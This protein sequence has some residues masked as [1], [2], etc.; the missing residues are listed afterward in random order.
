MSLS[1]VFLFVLSLS[2]CFALLIFSS[3]LVYL[4]AKNTTTIETHEARWRQEDLEEAGKKRKF[5]YEFGTGSQQANI[6]DL[7]WKRN[8]E[9]VFGKTWT[10]WLLP[11]SITST[12]I[13][14]E[15]CGLN[16]EVN[17]Q[18]YQRWKQDSELQTQ[19]NQ[20]MEEYVRRQRQERQEIV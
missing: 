10:Q 20:Q 3:F 13:Y 16:F 15:N 6:Y 2:F 1:L 19:L 8:L 14:D 11:V 17:Q 4:V 12:N 7:G 5:K 9:T 18:V